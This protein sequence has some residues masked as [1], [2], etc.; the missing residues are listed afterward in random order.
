[1]LFR[2]TSGGC[3][4]FSADSS[5]GAVSIQNG[6]TGF[7]MQWSGGAGDMQA[8]VTSGTL[9]RNITFTVVKVTA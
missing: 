7:E 1:M 8:R 9:P 5:A 4:V 2:S 6:I 3:A